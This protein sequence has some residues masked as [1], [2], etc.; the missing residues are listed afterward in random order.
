MLNIV[1]LLY[2]IKI[3][4]STGNASLS[5]PSIM[6]ISL[7]SVFTQTNASVGLEDESY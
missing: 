5:L 4:S 1:V 3:A 2:S 6:H 7:L